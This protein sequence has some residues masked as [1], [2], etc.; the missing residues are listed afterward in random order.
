LQ[1]AED[2]RK[3]VCFLKSIKSWD[4]DFYMESV[5]FISVSCVICMSYLSSV[6][7]SKCW[8]SPHIFATYCTTS[9][10]PRKWPVLKQTFMFI[11]WCK[12]IPLNFLC[13]II[14]FFSSKPETN[15]L[16]TV[17]CMSQKILHISYHCF[18]Y[19]EFRSIKNVCNIWC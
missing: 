5:P 12:L 19:Y 3:K 7:K 10:F 18:S 13:K 17:S 15:F 9:I 6:H 2:N 8:V 14:I 11:G 4:Q 1:K 16:L